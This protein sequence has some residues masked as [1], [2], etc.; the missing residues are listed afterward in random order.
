M[1]HG[2]HRRTRRRWSDRSASRARRWSDPARRRRKSPAS[3]SRSP[4]PARSCLHSSLPRLT[5]HSRRTA[6]LPPAIGPGKRQ[7]AGSPAPWDGCRQAVRS[8]WPWPGRGAG[9]RLLELPDRPLEFVAAPG[10]AEANDVA[11]VERQ[12]VRL[13]RLAGPWAGFVDAVREAEVADFHARC[14]T[15]SGRAY[16][17]PNGF[18]PLNDATTE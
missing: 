12:R 13:D 1:P 11:L 14:F 17:G 6:N 9:A 7:L 5:V 4:D 18:A 16:A 8:A 2:R 10:I 15:L 3:R